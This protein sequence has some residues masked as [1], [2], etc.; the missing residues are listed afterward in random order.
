MCRCCEKKGPQTDT[1]THRQGGAQCVGRLRLLGTAVKGCPR[2]G[3]CLSAFFSMRPCGAGLLAEMEMEEILLH[4]VD[5]VPQEKKEKTAP[6][7]TSPPL[8]PVLSSHQGGTCRAPRPN[9]SIYCQRVPQP[10]GRTHTH[11]PKHNQ[12]R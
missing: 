1:Q 6:C 7:W 9:P 8:R 2:S 12:L 11:H 4:S 5:E 10:S 3:F